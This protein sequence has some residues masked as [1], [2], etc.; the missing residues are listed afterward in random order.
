MAWVFSI[1]WSLF[2]QPALPPRGI[3]SRFNILEHT[4]VP[5][6]KVIPEILPDNTQSVSVSDGE[7]T[8]TGPHCPLSGSSL[9]LHHRQLHPPGPAGESS[10][11]IDTSVLRYIYPAFSLVQ[12]L[13]C[14]ALIGRRLTVVLSVAALAFLCHKDLALGSCLSLKWNEPKTQWTYR[15]MGVKNTDRH[16][17][18]NLCVLWDWSIWSPRRSQIFKAS[19]LH[20]SD[21][22]G[23]LTIGKDNF[24]MGGVILFTVINN[25][26]KK[27]HLFWS[28]SSVVLAG[29]NLS[30]NEI[31]S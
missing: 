5:H 31:F 1:Q 8:R 17:T 29:I 20:I 3:Y 13:H 23:I 28:N 18:V 21:S 4:R 24:K 19:M 12:L 10:I 14:W 9:G 26:I 16:Q 30:R 15:P 25:T 6:I 2:K 7:T 11:E 27:I 22:W